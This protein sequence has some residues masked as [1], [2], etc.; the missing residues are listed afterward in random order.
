[1][2]YI[3]TELIKKNSEK[4]IILLKVI[5]WNLKDLLNLY[6]QHK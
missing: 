1:M 3:R 6:F 2:S 4:S 5:L